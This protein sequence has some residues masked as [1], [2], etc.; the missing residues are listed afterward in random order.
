MTM[1]DPIASRRPPYCVF[2]A[3][4]LSTAT[5]APMGGVSSATVK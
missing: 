3:A 2:H 1:R 4:S 5:G